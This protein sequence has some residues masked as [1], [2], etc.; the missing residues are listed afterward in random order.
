[1]KQMKTMKKYKNL[2][3]IDFDINLIYKCPECKS[4]H[5]LSLKET[6]TKNFR[7]V[8][9]CDTIFKVK[10]IEKID[11]IYQTSEELNS[12]PIKEP[13]QELPIDFV[14]RCAT[15]LVGYGF[16]KDE[17]KN[18]VYSTHKIN[19]STDISAFIKSCILNFGETNVK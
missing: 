11:I 2:K 17:A 16:T 19:P 8:C 4:E 12:A 3:P 5:W 9:D 18:L 13:V 1:M 15:I 10:P 7:V 14:D 6:S